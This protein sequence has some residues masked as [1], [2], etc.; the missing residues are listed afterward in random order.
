M[1]SEFSVENVLFL[2]EAANFKR[3]MI[4]LGY[5]DEDV[6]PFDFL[7][8]VHAHKKNGRSAS[9]SLSMPS[10]LSFI[11]NN[12]LSNAGEPAM[13]LS[14]HESIKVVENMNDN[15]DTHFVSTSSFLRS[16][17]R[18]TNKKEKQAS[19]SKSKG[20]KKKSDKIEMN[21]N[22]PQQQKSNKSP[23]KEIFAAPKLVPSTLLCESETPKL[24]HV[25][26]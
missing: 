9:F 3:L 23:E 12:D 21:V 8:N 20:K 17:S 13:Q 11:S 25:S 14:L 7:E 24:D 18:T 26:S 19:K 6:V 5:I 10:K 4:K 2:I 15:I 16:L 22:N 1:Y